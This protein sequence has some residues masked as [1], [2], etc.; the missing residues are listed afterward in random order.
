MPPLP[1][2]IAPVCYSIANA[3]DKTRTNATFLNANIK[4]VV[5]KCWTYVFDPERTTEKDRCGSEKK[6]RKRDSTDQCH[7]LRF[8]DTIAGQ[9]R[10]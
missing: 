4:R 8:H 1:L 7:V 9:K 5:E 3:K 2:K 10:A 6:E